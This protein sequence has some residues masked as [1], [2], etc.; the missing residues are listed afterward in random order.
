[1]T[2]PKLAEKPMIRPVYQTGLAI[3]GVSE[4]HSPSTAGKRAI[5]R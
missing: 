1:M 4:V 5:A 2:Q 3:L